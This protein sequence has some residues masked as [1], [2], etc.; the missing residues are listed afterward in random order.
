M[1]GFAENDLFLIFCFFF[2]TLCDKMNL[3][4]MAPTQVM[5]VAMLLGLSSLTFLGVDFE[6]LRATKE[7]DGKPKVRS[8]KVIWV[9]RYQLEKNHGEKTK[10]VL[11]M[12]KH[13]KKTSKTCF[14]FGISKCV[15]LFFHVFSTGFYLSFYLQ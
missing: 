13:P 8:S 15:F 14:C 2:G 12:F 5:V 7:N 4:N 10:Q 3:L 6:G 9:S 1:A 11:R